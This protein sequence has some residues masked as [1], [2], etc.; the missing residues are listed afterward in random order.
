MVIKM[1]HYGACPSHIWVHKLSSI[2]Y[3]GRTKTHHKQDLHPKTQIKRVKDRLFNRL[4]SLAALEQGQ[5]KQINLKLI[6]IDL[7]RPAELRQ[8][9]K[10]GG[11]SVLIFECSKKRIGC[12]DDILAKLRRSIEILFRFTIRGEELHL[13]VETIKYKPFCPDGDIKSYLLFSVFFGRIF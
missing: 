12:P 5:Q 2:L 3:K 4:F 13:N 7:R 6:I 8:S 1:L 10:V 11:F 9:G